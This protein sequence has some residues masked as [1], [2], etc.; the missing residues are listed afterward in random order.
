MSKLTTF[1]I[2]LYD[3]NFNDCSDSINK[4]LGSEAKVWLL[5]GSPG[6]NGVLGNKKCFSKS[7]QWAQWVN[8]F[9]ACHGYLENI[10]YRGGGELEEREQMEVR[11]ERHSC[12]S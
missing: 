4:D 2:Q 9:P 8:T 1:T 12:R 3:F 6:H 7:Q 10:K 5:S 11:E